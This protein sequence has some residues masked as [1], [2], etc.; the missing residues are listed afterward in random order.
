MKAQANFLS[1]EHHTRPITL[2]VAVVCLGIG[3]TA[4]LLAHEGGHPPLPS[5]GATVQGNLMML[6]TNG[7]KAIGLKTEKV[8]LGN[9][10]RTIVANAILE[11]PCHQHAYATTLVAG[12][13]AAV[14]A[15][16]GDTVVAGQ[17]LARLESADLETL[18]TDMLQASSELALADRLV[19]HREKLESAISGRTLLETNAT[20]LQKASEFSVA[21]QKLRSLGLKHDQ[22]QQVRS[23]GQPIRSLAVTTPISGVISEAS[24]RAG[25]IVEP[26]EILYRIVDSRTLWA[27]AQVLESDLPAIRLGLPVTVKL[28]AIPERVFPG[29]IEYI[30]LAVHP[31]MHTLEVMVTLDNAQGLLRPGLFGQMSIVTQ[32]AIKTVIAPAAAV[33]NHGGELFALLEDEPGKLF[34]RK[35]KLGLHTSKQVEILDGLFPGDNVVTTGLQELGA[36]FTGSAESSTSQGTTKIPSVQRAVST[37]YELPQGKPRPIQAQIELP[38][39]GKVFASSNIRG[40]LLNLLVERGDRVKAGDVLA[41]V[42]SLELKNLQLQLL[43]NRVTLNLTKTSL[44]RMEPFRGA[45]NVPEKD[46]WQLRAKYDSHRHAEQSLIHKLKLAGLAEEEIERIE[47]LDLTDPQAGEKISMSLPIRAPAAG[48]VADFE[49]SI[50]QIVDTN[51]HLFE[52]HDLSRVWAKGFVFERDASQLATGQQVEVQLVCDP[53][54]RTLAGVARVSPMVTSQERVFE[55]WAEIENPDGKLKEGMLAR[56]FMHLKQPTRTPAADPKDARAHHS[57]SE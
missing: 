7:A 50:G 53:K 56:M 3:V 28:D 25:E 14:L 26:S 51:D 23:S 9:L 44:D 40:R 47:K 4:P 43:Q 35:L 32:Q 18:Q 45:G 11:V 31:K 37:G 38:T 36:L 15:R 1:R 22:L 17:E 46:I 10:Q 13:V 21:W 41:E 55:V 19:A 29:H 54:F 27:M 12:R 57:L 16:P 34:R 24:I 49:L 48:L 39:D 52:I 2:I 33:M 8:R 30:G 42:E 6:S 20:R 5:K